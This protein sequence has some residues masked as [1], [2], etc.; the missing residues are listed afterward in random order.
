MVELGISYSMTVSAE[1]LNIVGK[2]ISNNLVVAVTGAACV[3]LAF[4][5]TVFVMSLQH[6][7]VLYSARPAAASVVV[8]D[9]LFIP[10][11][12]SLF[13]VVVVGAVAFSPVARSF[14]RCF[15][16]FGTRLES[17]GRFSRPVTHFA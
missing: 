13:E 10:L 7:R 17:V 4:T 8:N 15:P 6:N 12:V 5:I 16:A 1:Q 11:T 9:S 2:V 3:A 14:T